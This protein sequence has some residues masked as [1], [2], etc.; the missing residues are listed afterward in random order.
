[1]TAETKRAAI[2][3]VL[4][5]GCG[6]IARRHVAN[7]RKLGV[8][9]VLVFDPDLSRV[10]HLRRKLDCEPVDSLQAGLDALPGAALIC[11]P[12]SLHAN[13]ALA[14]IARGTPCF[15]EKP[16]AHTVA[17]AERVR[18]AAARWRVPVVVGY[19]L[20]FHP[21][22][23]WIRRGLKKSRW[24]PIQYIRAQIGQYLPDWRPWQDYR[25]SYTSRKSLGGGILLDASHEIDLTMHFA[26][27]AKSVFCAADRLSALQIDVEDTAELTLRFHNGAMGSVHLDMIRRTYD[28]SCQLLCRDGVVE[29]SYQDGTVREYRV[30]S[31]KWTTHTFTKDGNAMYLA[32][33]KA[34]LAMAR[35]VSVAG[36]AGP[37]EGAAALRIVE[38]AKHSARTGRTHTLR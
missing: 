29:W 12:P 25:K 10:E 37:E 23:A 31:E 33:M 19:Q 22:I 32:E 38:A 30:R 9:R 13:A 15:I 17:A 3:T 34:F 7:L 8:K 16:L 26:G 27:P 1:M 24:G 14:A 36:T 35:R 20:R 21:A 2:S 28:R 4:V 11:T 18:R 5:V 6:S